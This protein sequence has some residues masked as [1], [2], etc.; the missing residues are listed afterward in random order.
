MDEFFMDHDFNLRQA[1]EL[2][3]RA[4]WAAAVKEADAILAHDLRFHDLRPFLY[5]NKFLGKLYGPAYHASSKLIF[6]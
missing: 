6:K 1:S 3:T 5:P 2:Q 4:E